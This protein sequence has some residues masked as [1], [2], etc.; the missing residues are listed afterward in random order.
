[1]LQGRIAQ[2]K[3]LAQDHWQK[4]AMASGGIAA[5]GLA[6]GLF[7]GQTTREEVQPEPQQIDDQVLAQLQTQQV[8]QAVQSMPQQEYQSA[9]QAQQPRME[10]PR[11][12]TEEDELKHRLR[13]E[14]QRNKL[15]DEMA[16]VA[17]QQ[18]MYGVAQ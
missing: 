14:K 3:G 6:T 10:L 4:A 2:L 12:F 18:A 7:M 8:A 1:M 16:L 9:P 13:L 5:G 11:S 15:E 17:A